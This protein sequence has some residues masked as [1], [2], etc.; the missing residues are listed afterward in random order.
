MSVTEEL[1]RA[2]AARCERIIAGIDELQPLLAPVLPLSGVA[3]ES[4]STIQQIAAVA[5]LKRYE[6]LQDALGRLFRTYL[7]W[8]AEDVRAMTR[9]DQANQMEK[10]GLVA[11]ADVW[12]AAADLR[13][14]L[15]HEYPLEEAEQLQRVNQCWAAIP[16]LLTIYAA[17]DRR[18]RDQGLKQ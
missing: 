15:V 9:R 7:T 2:G 17:L 1:L 13:N 16:D 11:D 12:I 6:Q 10:F 3:A 18:L 5:L 4:L 14:R 8:E